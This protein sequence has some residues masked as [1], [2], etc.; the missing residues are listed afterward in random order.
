MAVERLEIGFLLDRQWHFLRG[1]METTKR[2][3]LLALAQVMERT[4]T[5]YAVIGG[6]ALQVHRTEPRNTVDIDVAILS[7]DAIPRAELEAAGFTFHGRFAHSENWFGPE[8]VPIQFTEDPALAGPIQRAI[9]L[10]LDGI[11]MR[12]IGR[13]DLLR[14]KLRAGSDPARRRSKRRQDIVDAENLV[15]D[16]PELLSELSEAERAILDTWPT[17]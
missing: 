10:E 4:R 8:R 15:D 6:I 13:A 7:F 12:F 17:D 5:P 9:T 1:E 11:P 2:P 16:A 3:A 14:E